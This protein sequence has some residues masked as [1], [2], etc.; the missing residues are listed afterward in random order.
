M[1]LLNQQQDQQSQEAYISFQRFMNYLKMGQ[2]AQG[3]QLTAGDQIQAQSNYQNQL[4]QIGSDF[5]SKKTA[6]LQ[7]EQTKADSLKATKDAETEAER[8]AA[9]EKLVQDQNTWASLIQDRLDNAMSGFNVD[10]ETGEYSYADW[11]K[12]MNIYNLA[13]GKM[14]VSQQEMM[15]FYLNSIPHKGTDSQIR[16]QQPTDEPEENEEDD[17]PPTSYGG[18]GGGG[19]SR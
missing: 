9:E 14:S 15:E 13:K 2:S 4:N 16:T 18:G 12:I 5:A 10:E 6:V 17:L 3:Q 8:A 1:G 11:Q 19:R 7:E